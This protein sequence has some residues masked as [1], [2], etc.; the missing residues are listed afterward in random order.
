MKSIL[1]I[2]LVTSIL[3]S[4]GC[5]FIPNY[6]RPEV[7]LTQEWPNKTTS[8][9]QFK[10]SIH[11]IS[12]E[13]LFVDPILQETIKTT[14]EH[15]HNLRIA[16]LNVEAAR[17][18]YRVEFSSLFPDLDAQ[19][20]GT[21]SK[22]IN[23]PGTESTTNSQ[24]RMTSE[25]TGNLS[26]AFELDL[27][28]RLRSLSK[29]AQEEYLATEAAREAARIA[30]IA[31]TANAYLQWQADRKILNLTK[32]T[33]RAQKKSYQLISQSHE[34]GIASGL[35]LAQIRTAVETAKA[36][37][38]LFSRR[39]ELDKNALILLMGQE[40]KTLLKKAEL[41]THNDPVIENLPVDLPS[42]VLLVRPDIIQAEHKLKAA[43]ADIGAARSAFF[44]N[45]SLTGAYG[46]ASRDL[47]G[48]FSGDTSS[49]W[50][51]A[52]TITIPIFSAGRGKANLDLR[53]IRK[54]IAIV[55]Y[56]K[57][58]RTAFK[59]VTDELASRQT[60]GEQLNAQQALVKSTQNAYHLSYA[61]YQ[62]GID[63]FLSV[64]DAQRSLYKAQQDAIDVRKEQIVN[65][66]N[67]YKA[68]GGGIK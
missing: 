19:L 61:R 51:F 9:K 32:D 1:P 10:E 28:G 53:H 50:S 68:L 4:A 59:E 66:V 38:A 5:S 47:S 46:L 7:K 20:S 8:K 41:V 16:A 18:L 43:N 6:K 57:A 14:L 48:L 15:N 65:I 17:A 49:T 44:P 29:A 27:F 3:S 34:K 13:D 25:Y 37:E 24:D 39:V 56:E 22:R 55:E 11:D 52:P 2:L 26:T 31:E 63:N 54:N 30:L 42:E 60:L 62:K 67:L 45:I 23:Q 21:R 64:L 33:L 40:D 35:D 12:W 36:N 58:I